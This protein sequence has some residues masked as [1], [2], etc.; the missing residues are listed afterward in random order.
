MGYLNTTNTEMED[1]IV[2]EEI[3]NL[4]QIWKKWVWLKPDSSWML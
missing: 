1:H 2:L 3:V 4:G